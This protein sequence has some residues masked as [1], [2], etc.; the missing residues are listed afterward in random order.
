MVLP[1]EPFSALAEF[2]REWVRPRAGVTLVA[3]SRVYPGREDR[4][5]RYANAVGWD[6]L[7]GD[8]VDRVVDLEQLLP[9]DVEAE[10]F[11]HIDCVSVLEHTRRPWE[12]A[13]NLEMLLCDCGTLLVT[14]PFIWREHSYPG[15]FW[16]FT[17]AGLKSLFGMVEWQRV[18]Y[19]HVRFTEEGEK[20][21]G[22]KVQGFPYFA[23]TEVFAFGRVLNDYTP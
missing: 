5:T 10:S 22:K 18:V 16:R 11:D 4:R 17:I 6:A 19:A 23:R 1:S 8:G 20:I 2:E 12:V 9:D 13:S 14:V 3:G 21:N 7:P 15:D